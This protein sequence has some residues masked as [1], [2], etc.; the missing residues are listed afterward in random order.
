MMMEGP[1]DSRSGALAFGGA[2]LIVFGLWLFVQNSG[3]IDQKLLDTVNRSAGALVVVGLGVL[4][5]LLS[6]RGVLAGPRP[7]ARLYRSRSDRVFSGVLGGLGS[8]LGVDAVLL[9]VAFILLTLAGG[10]GLVV[11]YIILWAIV[12]EEPA[13]AFP[14]QPIPPAPPIPGA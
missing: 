2:A 13:P 11:V 1:K 12:P 4:V 10:F 5:I 7:G 3:L 14:D 6:R 9:R 8:Y